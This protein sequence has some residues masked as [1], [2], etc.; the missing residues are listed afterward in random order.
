MGMEEMTSSPVDPLDEFLAHCDYGKV[1]LAA[2]TSEMPKFRGRCR[3]FIDRLASLLLKSASTCSLVSKC[4]CCFYPELMLDGDDNS[5]FDLFIEL[6]GILE[7][8]DS[9]SRDDSKAAV[10][11]YDV[12]VIEKRRQHYRLERAASAIPDVRSIYWT[13]LKFNHGDML[14]CL[15][16]SEPNRQCPSFSIDLS[17]CGLTEGSVQLCCRIVQPNVLSDGYSPQSLFTE[18]TLGLLR[19]ALA[20]AGVFFVGSDFNVW[21]DLCGPCMDSFIEA[22]CGLYI[23]FLAKRRRSS[24]EHYPECNRAN[25]FSVLTRDLELVL[26]SGVVRIRLCERRKMMRVKFL[27]RILMLHVST[28]RRNPRLR[29]VVARQ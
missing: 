6:C 20:K 19:G 22:F 14:C 13:T 10:D 26:L 25:R 5:A 17:G 24:D 9:L 3:K 21:K 11:E 28:N 23:E 8:C 29:L 7:E 16:V 2:K 15:I 1:L 4:L 18:S 12:Y 27:G